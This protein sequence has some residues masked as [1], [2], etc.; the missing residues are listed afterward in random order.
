MKCHKC[1]SGMLRRRTV[2]GKN[3]GNKIW[4]CSNEFCDVVFPMGIPRPKVKPILKDD[5]TVHIGS[6]VMI[7]LQPDDEVMKVTIFAQTSDLYQVTVTDP[8]DP[9]AGL[10][11]DETPIGRALLGKKVGQKFTYKG[12]MNDEFHGE[13]L[14]IVRREDCHGTGGD[15]P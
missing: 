2:F 5:S 15:I 13:I 14:E 7:K 1:G 8:G 10:I 9:E 12:P 3:K 11:S 4:A 6:T